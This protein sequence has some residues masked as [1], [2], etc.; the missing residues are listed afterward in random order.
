MKI[1]G[2]H[3]TS[4]TVSDLDRS[5]AFYVGLLGCEVI[6]QR[7]IRDG[8]FRQIVGLPGAVVRAAQLRIPGSP[9]VLE[10]FEYV[11]PRGLPADVRNAH[12]GSSHIAWF[13]DDLPAAYAELAEKGVAFR[14]PPVLID[15]GANRGGWAAYALDPDGIT[16]ELFQPPRRD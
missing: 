10:L 9:H 11:T 12:P 5:L 16:V 2:A 6:W 1:T 7:E 14:S 13:V 3:H 8:Y 15:A 4:Y